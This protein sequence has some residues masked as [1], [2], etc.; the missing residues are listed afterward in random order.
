MNTIK[1]NN[2]KR[3]LLFI[4]TLM[5]AVV[6]MAQLSKKLKGVKTTV[7]ITPGDG[8]PPAAARKPKRKPKK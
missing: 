7:L 4:L 5:F 6:S 1:S 8:I 2:M 3:I